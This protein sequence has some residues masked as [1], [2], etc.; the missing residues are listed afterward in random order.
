MF[1]EVHGPFTL[2]LSWGTGSHAPV[3]QTS[4]MLNTPVAPSKISSSFH[5]E[6]LFLFNSMWGV[7]N[8]GNI[9]LAKSFENY[10]CNLVPL[11]GML[12]LLYFTASGEISDK[13]LNI[14]F[15]GFH[16]FPLRTSQTLLDFFLAFHVMIIQPT[17]W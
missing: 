8:C 10:Q 5:H 3:P 4:G 6:N 17:S 16:W 14:E 12:Y 11:F 13:D 15:Y 9:F 1:N 7:Q 2:D